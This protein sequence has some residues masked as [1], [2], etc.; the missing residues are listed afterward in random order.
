[1]SDF[2]R[3]DHVAHRHRIKAITIWKTESKGWQGNFQNPDGSWR[4]MHGDTPGEALD[5]VLATYQKTGR[6]EVRP[7]RRSSEDLI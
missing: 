1:M 7:V 5:A 4:I 6:E 3:L 2:D